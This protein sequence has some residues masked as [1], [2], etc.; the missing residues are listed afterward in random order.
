VLFAAGS[1]QLRPEAANLFKTTLA[2][3]LLFLTL[4]VLQ[5]S[6]AFHVTDSREAAYLAVSGF[7]GISICDTLYFYCLRAIGAW[8][9]LVISCLAPPLTAVLSALV[10]EDPMG[11]SGV[12]GMWIALAGVVLAIV[13]G[14]R[15]GE[16]GLSFTRAGTIVGVIMAVLV[17]IAIILTKVGTAR[18]GSIEASTQRILAGVVGI[19]LIEAVRGKLGRTFRAALRPPAL[20]KLVAGSV[21]GTYVAYVFFIAGIKNAHPGV[22][23]ALAATAPAFVIPFSIV[24][25]REKVS[26]L[27]VLGT[28]MA[29]AGILILFLL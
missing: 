17:S 14:W 7:L 5:G 22:A 24:F 19:I 12:L 29:I 4:L 9:T 23:T 13:G 18:T 26:V 15:K 1:K 20:K 2:A 27:A 28:A 21:I 8:R 6:R 16:D 3:A 25:L 11:V 10:L